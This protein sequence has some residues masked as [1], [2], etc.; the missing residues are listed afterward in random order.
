MRCATYIGRVGALAF[1]LGVGTGLAATPWVASA[2]SDDSVASS[3]ASPDTPSESGSKR[4]VEVSSPGPDTTAAADA[5]DADADADADSTTSETTEPAET[6]ETDTSD[7]GREGNDD[8]ASDSTSAPDGPAV[9]D[10]DVDADTPT[11]EAT[12]PTPATAVTDITM[13]AADTMAPV[14]DSPPTMPAEAPA[15]LTLAVVARRDAEKVVDAVP[16][17]DRTE[18]ELVTDTPPAR[19]V[20]AP[21]DATPEPPVFTGEPSIVS[22]ILSATFGFI[23]AIGNFFGVDLIFPVT[24]LLSSDSPPW[25]TTIGLNVE[26]REQEGMT[27]WSLRSPS[28]TSEEIVIAV[29]GGGLVLQPTVF[30]WLAYG[31]IAAN[32]GATVLVP[33]FPQ[34]PQGTAA[35]VVPAMADLITAQIDQHGTENISVFGDSSGG[36]IALVTVQEM[37]RRGDA[38]PSRMVLSSPGTDATLSNPGIKDVDDPVLSAAPTLAT[39]LKNSQ[40][41]ADGLDL[42]DPLVSPLFGSLAG[43][44][45]TT[46]YAGSRDVVAPDV[47]L[48]REKALA[49]PGADFTFVLRNG[50]PHDFAIL[51]ILPETAALLPDIYLQLGIVAEPAEAKYAENQCGGPR[52]GNSDDVSVCGLSP[53]GG[54]SPLVRKDNR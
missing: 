53:D 35:T 13:T 15:L 24:G 29:H 27:V 9:P 44:P 52:Y 1:A 28:S 48:L 4:G 54:Q 12:E 46:V 20:T 40:L 16:P 23:G 38:V 5:A 32:T 2:H 10:E 22:E 43:L 31:A 39:V 26:Q 7:R 19:T 51:T 47:L 41:W 37:V 50:E 3:S 34:L 14:A 17:A 42:T 36:N 8:D 18:T 21:L 33:M 30:N 25:F 11:T 45:P 6:T 49:T